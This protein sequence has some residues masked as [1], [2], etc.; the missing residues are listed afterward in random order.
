M[1]IALRA[2][3]AWVASA[4]D[5]NPAIPAG[6][7]AGDMMLCY[8]GMKPYSVSIP[9]P[10]PAGWTRLTAGSGTNGTVANGIDV[11]SVVWATFYREW[12]SGDADPYFTVTGGNTGLAVVKSFSKTAASWETPVAAKGSDNTSGAAF[13]LAMD[14]DIGITVGDMLAHFATLPGNNRTFGSPTITAP[15]A[16]I[17]AATESPATEGTTAGG[18]DLE[19]SASHALCTAGTST[20]APT[21]A[22]TLSGAQTGGGSVVRL[23]EASSGGTT[24]DVAS[25]E[26]ATAT[27]SQVASAV[28]IGARTESG[29]ATD[30]PTA[31]AIFSTARTESVAVSDSETGAVETSA[32]QTESI[33][34]SDQSTSNVITV[35][36]RTE[37]L[38]VADSHDGT[39]SSGPQVHDVAVN[40]ALSFADAQTGAAV[41]PVSRPE[42]SALSESATASGIYA[43]PI[44]E[45]LAPAESAATT[46]LFQ[47][48]IAELLASLDSSTGQFPTAGGSFTMLIRGGPVLD[49]S[50]LGD[51]V[52]VGSVSGGPVLDATVT[53]GVV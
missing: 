10:D 38:T 32:S 18:N 46:A 4:T 51:A 1:T 31:S 6:T 2:S 33:T 24:H 13:S 14:V 37:V 42:V 15:S 3:G 36:A 7:A 23:R 11:G 45:S 20:A 27:A 19:S 41:Y 9:D 12:Q 43:A 25:D 16:T 47:A 8:V 17:E 53:V 28:F 30:T 5:L 44:T 35:V 48:A 34:V 29:T 22:W 49:S 26:S 50:V 52:L 40:E 21:C 39:I